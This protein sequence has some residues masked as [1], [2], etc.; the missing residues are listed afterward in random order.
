MD[1]EQG[2]RTVWGGTAREA[3]L[4]A[5]VDSVN[6][7]AGIGVK[8]AAYSEKDPE[9]GSRDDGGT[10]PNTGAEGGSEVIP[11]EGD[12]S[13]GET[14]PGEGDETGVETIPGEGDE[15]GGEAIPGE[16]DETGGETTPGEGDETGGETTPSEGDETGG[17]TEPGEGDEID[18][19]TEP[20]EGDEADSETD[21]DEEEESDT[22]DGKLSALGNARSG[23]SDFTIDANGTLTAYNGPGGDV[24]IPDTVTA[25]GNDVFKGKTNITSVIIPRNVVS[26][27]K[28]AFSGC[29]GMVKVTLNE[30]LQTIG[31]GAFYGAAFGKKGLS[32]ITNGT[33]TIPGSV[34]SIGGAAFSSS[35]YLET[36]TFENGTD[37]LVM[38]SRYNGL[39]AR[40]AFK[41]CK[42]L[43]QVIL[44]DQLVKLQQN[45]FEGCSALEEV[46]FGKYLE[47]IGNRA[48]YN[49]SSLQLIYLSESLKTIE[50][51][52]FLNCGMLEALYIPQTVTTIGNNILSLKNSPKAVIY[53]V[54]GSKAETYAKDNNIPF[55]DEGELESI[56]YVTGISLNRSKITVAGEEVIG[57]EFALTAT[58]RPITAQDKRVD[59]KSN[60]E[61]VAHVNT[62]SGKVTIKGY[63]TATITATARG[64]NNEI[65]TAT[66]MVTVLRQWSDEEKETICQ[67]LQEANADKLTVV[68]NICETVKDISLDCP[69]ELGLKSTDWRLP[70]SISTGEE[71]TYDVIV[72]KEGYEK[73]VVSGIKITGITVEG[74][75]VSGANKVQN[76]KS[77]ELSVEIQTTGG[78]LPADLY[79]IK[80]ETPANSGVSLTNPEQNPVTVT[81]NANKTATV[82]GYLLL[83]KDGKP[84]DR[85][86]SALK[87]KQWFSASAKVTVTDDAVADRIEIEAADQNGQKV[88]LASLRELTNIMEPVEY[89]LSAKVYSGEDP[90]SNSTLQWKSTNPSVA[91]V[92]A[93]GNTATLRVKEKGAAVISVLASKNGGFTES[94]R[95]VV[96]DSK[97]R[98]EETGITLNLNQIQPSAVIH[99]SPSDGYAIAEESLAVKKENGTVS[100]FTISQVADRA[101]EYR[102]S[103]RDGSNPAP[104]KQKV[105]LQMKTSAGEQEAHSLPLTITISRQLPKITVIQENVFNLY[106][107]G[108]EAKITVKADTAI[109][110]IKYIP[111]A[112][113]GP[114]LVLKESNPTEGY[115]TVTAEGRTSAN[116]KKTSAKG[117]L[118]ITFDGYQADVAYDKTFTVKVN[119][120][121]PVVLAVPVNT[122][123][124]PETSEYQETELN[125]TAISFLLKADQQ[126]ITAEA[127]WH[128]E[129]SGNSPTGVTVEPSSEEQPITVTFDDRA[130]N[131]VALKFKVTND[132]WIDQAGVKASCTIKKGNTPEIG[133][134]NSKLILNTEY[135][136]DKY[137]PVGIALCVK[138]HP[139]R[140]IARLLSVEGKDAKAEAVREEG[141]AFELKESILQVGIRDKSLFT[142]KSVKYTYL[143]KGMDERGIP[144]SG[145]LTVTVTKTPTKAMVKQSGSID[146]LN[147]EGTQILCK[148]TIKNYTDTIESVYLY[149]SYASSFSAKCEDGNV[150]IKA[151]EGKQ[152]KVK[153]TYKLFLRIRLA[154]GV[155]LDSEVKVTPKQNNP[156]LTQDIKK[157]VLFEASPGQAYGK[158]IEV[159][160]VKEGG[161]EIKSIE[162]TNGG[163]TF[164]YEYDQANRK[165]ILY[166]LDNATQKVNK[167]YK[168]KLA[169]RFKDG[170]ANAAPVYVT[171]SVNYKK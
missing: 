38:S 148:P 127:G 89:Q 33:L 132:N 135:G 65:K 83:K 32:E 123:L 46:E 96:K 130:K 52:A 31:E 98:L 73:A 165:G 59:F 164:G 149:G 79:E 94:F 42:A 1:G 24:T 146:L 154:S 85:K 69:A 18:G 48:F 75:S 104:G 51:E 27:G 77:T 142:A 152:L 139:E 19:E 6:E 140:R 121:L 41:D 141:F 84:A 70:Y 66:C 156:R 170:A 168:L 49:C 44:P 108:A 43:R 68:T 50:A 129:L 86:N 116:Y 158:E 35:A 39:S 21:P 11:G 153:T 7:E 109:A 113:S 55:R 114:K 8:S 105:F 92:R 76:G 160:P 145:S 162:L 138:N 82:T 122:V 163:D 151:R 47:S 95:V 103:I 34:T 56:R 57:K 9:G 167:T 159:V 111:S 93:Q 125:K 157:T 2:F 136:L 117:K 53:G 112:S 15:T 3:D 62:S 124:Y 14:I 36:V 118:R 110:E 40:G 74:I 120:N 22:L 169:V 107:N 161:P 63:G 97:P 147:R 5:N 61:E 137:D 26:I 29:T 88:E 128:M 72:E 12:G 28:N 64:K 58:V 143:V 45:T 126:D 119:K 17:E 30:G 20:G 37:E 71:D 100:D 16:G 25:I 171:V 78:A 99:I 166:V 54:R 131:S 155:V 4:A 115:F 106:E 90:L 133:F 91:E 60:N 87:G 150:V 101:T 23:E 13:G 80:W 81:G 102:I 134:S 10:K 144:V 67:K